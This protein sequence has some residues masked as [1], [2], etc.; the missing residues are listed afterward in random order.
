M[1]KFAD[2]TPGPCLTSSNDESSYR[3]EVLSVGLDC[4]NDLECFQNQGFSY[5]NMVLMHLAL[6][7]LLG[8]PLPFVITTQQVWI[9]GQIPGSKNLHH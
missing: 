8:S 7:E 4:C 3:R 9:A 2:D 6:T 5:N 1:S